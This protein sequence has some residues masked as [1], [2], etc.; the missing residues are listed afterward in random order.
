VK[1]FERPKIEAEL[2]AITRSFAL[3]SKTP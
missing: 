3:K 1:A 2:H